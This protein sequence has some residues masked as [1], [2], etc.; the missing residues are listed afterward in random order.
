MRPD[1]SLFIC[2]KSF[3]MNEATI[4]EAAR[5]IAQADALVIGAGAGMGVDSGLPDFRGPEGFWRAYPAYAKL[6]LAFE[7][8]ASPDHFAADP[9]L[10]WGFYGHRTNLYRSTKPHD[11]F[12]ILRRW[13]ETMPRGGF[14]F[15]SNVDDHFGRAGFDRDRVVEIHGSIEWRQCLEGCRQP[16]FPADQTLIG[17]DPESFRA[18]PPFPACPA[19]GGVARPNILMFGDDGFIGN[20]TDAQ[21]DRFNTWLNSLHGWRVVVVELGAGQAIPT[22]RWLSEQLVDDLGAKLIRINVREA[23]VP[24]GQISLPGPALATLQAL[25][26][27][28]SRL[29]S[30]GDRL[31]KR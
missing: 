6:G 11:G 21:L 30:G 12:A 29:I 10:G 9:A 31:D 26:Q 3:T 27:V 24:P 7:D 14:V 8:M 18:S 19:C 23:G 2:W 22:V 17:V 5:R 4:Q 13:T 25:D 28:V 16:V 15:T 1:P 20:R